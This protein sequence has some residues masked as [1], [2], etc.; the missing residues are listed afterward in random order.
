MKVRNM[1]SSRGNAVPNQF[2]ITADDGTYF[3]SY[4]TVIAHKGS[5]GRISLDR[6]A[7]DYST[8]TGK[9]RNQ[10][11]GE[12]KTDT[13]RKINGGEYSLTDLN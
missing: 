7:W 5:N 10:F 8:T 13:L 12:N 6:A 11:L 4:N 9:Y 1:T 3:Q 2:I